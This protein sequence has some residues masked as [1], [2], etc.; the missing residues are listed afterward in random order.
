GGGAAGRARGSGRADGIPR[1][2]GAGRQGADHGR[3][4]GARDADAERPA[5][6]RLPRGAGARSVGARRVA[7]RASFVR[8]IARPH[9]S[10]RRREGGMGAVYRVHSVMSDRVVAAL[11][12]LKPTAGGE[13]RVRFIREA[14]ALSTLSHPAIVRVMAVGEDPRR[15]LPYLAMELAHGETLK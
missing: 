10:G 14:E 1:T 11:K 2:R 15:E 13:A 9:A 3:V 7:G 6:G 4:A 12:I 5:A 8:G